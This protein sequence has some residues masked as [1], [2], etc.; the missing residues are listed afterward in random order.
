MKWISPQS[1]IISNILIPQPGHRVLEALNIFM[2]HDRCIPA[3]MQARD[4]ARNAF[5][6]NSAVIIN[7]RLAPESDT[8][9]PKSRPIKLFKQNQNSKRKCSRYVAVLK[10]LMCGKM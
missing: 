8:I 6:V 5:V 1:S 3:P 2:S 4:R 7:V 10:S 9:K